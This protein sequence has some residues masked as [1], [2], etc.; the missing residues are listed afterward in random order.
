MINDR[1]NRGA[2]S[3]IRNAISDIFNTYRRHCGRGRMWGTE[4]WEVMV[5]MRVG[6]DWPAMA[7]CDV[8]WTPVASAG[9]VLMRGVGIE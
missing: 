7:S 1:R 8:L 2:E 5:A 9:S 4:E 6:C 3:V